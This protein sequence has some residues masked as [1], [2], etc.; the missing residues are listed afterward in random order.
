[1]LDTII[2]SEFRKGVT[3]IESGE[4]AKALSVLE[5]LQNIVQNVPELHF[6]LGIAYSICE[7][8]AKAISEFDKVIQMMPLNAGALIN[9]AI[10]L[11]KLGKL[12]AAIASFDRA[13]EL[14]NGFSEAYLGKANVLLELGEVEAAISLYH[15]VINVDPTNADAYSN[16]GKIY[17]KQNNLNEAKILFEKSLEINPLDSIAWNDLGQVLFLQKNHAQAKSAFQNAIDQ[18]LKNADAYINLGNLYLDLNNFE[19]AVSFY[20]DSIKQNPINS[21][22]YCNL[23]FA[24]AK[25][26]KYIDAIDYY[27][28]SIHCDESNSKAYEGLAGCYLDNNDFERATPTYKKSIELDP[29]NYNSV[30]NLAFI[31]LALGDYE[32]GWAGYESRRFAKMVKSKPRDFAAELWLG[33]KDISNK[34]VLLHHEQGLGDTIQMLRYVPLIKELGATPIL[35]VPNSIRTIAGTVLQDLKVIGEGNEIPNIDYQ[36]PLMSLPFAFKTDLSTIPNSVPYLRSSIKTVK[37]FNGVSKNNGKLKIGISWSGS[38]QHANDINRSIPLAKLMPLFNSNVEFHSLHNEYRVSDL[39]LMTEIQNLYDHSALLNDFDDTAGLIMNMD[40]VISVDTSVAH[41]AGALGHKLWVLIPY[42]SDFRWLL[43]RI[44]SPWYPTA[45]L[46]RQ[47]E[48]GNW[49][50]V[51]REIKEALFSV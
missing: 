8:H 15:Q 44:D 49:D 21:K 42:S 33:D 36:C 39:S 31:Q 51:V 34:L 45:R 20:E 3:L 37:K 5:P 4:G 41:L 32:N 24:Y 43:N 10:A 38:E 7:K 29:N 47:P 30:L 13:I 40:L 22:A 18:D 35:L 11:K 6:L 9:K 26:K 25:Q 12:D 1:M 27:H 17:A 28:K 16:L 50:S 2:A 46:F 14:S 48:I 23:A 19:L